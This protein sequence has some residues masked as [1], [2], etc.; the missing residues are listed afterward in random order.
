MT[1]FGPICGPSSGCDWTFGSVI[2]EC[3]DGSWGVLGEGGGGGRDLI[4]TVGTMAPCFFL[5]DS[6]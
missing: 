4:I 1:Y 6:H 2:Q 5:V 3:V